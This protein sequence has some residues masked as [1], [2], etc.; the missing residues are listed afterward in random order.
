MGNEAL[1]P[2]RLEPVSKAIEELPLARGEEWSSDV[3]LHLRIVAGEHARPSFA[4]IV[5]NGV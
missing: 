5:R 2:F 4:R 3:E 1:V